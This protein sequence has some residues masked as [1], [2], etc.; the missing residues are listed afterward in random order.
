MTHLR[1]HYRSQRWP[2]ALTISHPPKY[3]RPGNSTSPGGD[4]ELLL[5]CNGNDIQKLSVVESIYIIGQN[6]LM[7]IENCGVQ[8][9]TYY[10]QSDTSNTTHKSPWKTRFK[11]ALTALASTRPG[12]E[13]STSSADSSQK[14]VNTQTRRKKLQA[15]S[16]FLTH[17]VVIIFLNFLVN[18]FVITQCYPMCCGQMLPACCNSNSDKMYY[19]CLTII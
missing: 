17:C 2:P 5:Y 4:G 14:S 12:Q 16:W 7:N 11:R 19:K 8:R 9:K 1:G 13:D 18:S 6:R 10:Q 3:S 15:Q